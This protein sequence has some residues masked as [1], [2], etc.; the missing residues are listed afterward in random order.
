[1]SCCAVGLLAAMIRQDAAGDPVQPKA[2]LVAFRHLLVPAPGGGEGVGNH[3][4]GVLGRD[5]TSQGVA[6]N[7]GVV[8]LVCGAKPLVSRHLVH[9]DLD[10]WPGR[11][12]QG[13]CRDRSGGFTS[14]PP[15]AKRDGLP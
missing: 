3:V 1:M 15:A 2:D 14:R 4:G 13:I 9:G 5:G 11:I 8:G 6:Q 12:L 10:R 7:A